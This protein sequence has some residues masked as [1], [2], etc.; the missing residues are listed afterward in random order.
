MG[1][2]D[3]VLGV[4]RDHDKNATKAS[5]LLRVW[6][7]EQLIVLAITTARYPELSKLVKTRRKQA[8]IT[9]IGRCLLDGDKKRAKLFS[10]ALFF[11]GAYLNGVFLL[12]LSNVVSSDVIQRLLK[13]DNKLYALLLITSSKIRRYLQAT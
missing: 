13:S 12:A 1:Y 2:I 11:E 10:K 8:Y 4:H 9:R 5:E 7:E 3:E 6:F